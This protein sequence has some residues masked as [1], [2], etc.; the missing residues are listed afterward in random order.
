MRVVE[1]RNIC[2][3][4]GSIYYLRKFKG[5]AVIELPG[6]DFEMPVEFCIET[7]PLGAKK[8]DIII[9]ESINYPVVPI[10]SALKTY[11]IT[12][13]SKGKQPI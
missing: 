12:A 5:D 3:E 7:D 13:D 9:S 2:R 8:I 10:K 6:G 1:I 4:E 11:I